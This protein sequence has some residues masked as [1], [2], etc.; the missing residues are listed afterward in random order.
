MFLHLIVN[1]SMFFR[2]RTYSIIGSLACAHLQMKNIHV[3]VVFFG[4]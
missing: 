3:W 1:F 4:S 2:V